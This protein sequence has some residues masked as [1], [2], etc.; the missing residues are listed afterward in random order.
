[1]PYIRKTHLHLHFDGFS[2]FINTGTTMD[3]LPADITYPVFV[4]VFLLAYHEG[5]SFT[6]DAFL[7]DADRVHEIFDDQMYQLAIT[8][9]S[10]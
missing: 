3:A 6:E 1:M 8:V 4:N 9:S 7:K 10:L 2:P 5:H